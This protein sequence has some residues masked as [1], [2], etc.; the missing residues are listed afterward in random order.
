MC[1]ALE[2]CPHGLCILVWDRV[3]RKD[4]VAKGQNLDPSRRSL[5]E[6]LAF[7]TKLAPAGRRLLRKT[8]L[9]VSECVQLTTSSLEG[10]PAPS[11][12][13]CS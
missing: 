4:H 5:H 13:G 12:W 6:Q 9:P 1:K 8:E 7:S 10:L 2:H 3:N 11:G